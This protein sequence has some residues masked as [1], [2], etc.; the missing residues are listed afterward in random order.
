[1]RQLII[2]TET[3]GLDPKR[4]PP[5]HRIRGARAR[6]PPADRPLPAPALRSRARSRLRRDRGARQDV[7]GPEGPAARFAIAPPRCSTS[8]AAPS[9]SST[10]R[11]S[12][13]RSSTSS[14]SRRRMPRLRRVAR[15]RDRHAGAR[16][17]L[18]PGQAQ[19]PGR[20][21]RAL[22]RVQRAPHA[23]RRAARRAAPGRG[24]P[25][26]DARPGV[27]YHRHRR[28]AGAVAA[29]RSPAPARAGRRSS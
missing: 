25:R 15:R 1:M 5:H 2:D 29:S 8:C 14:S 20:A 26:D 24:L 22:R 23:A 28:R 18:L 9:G 13:S 12:T 6:R 3:T 4:R 11:R 19:Q 17:R 27:A 21:V 16:A 7:G 10:T